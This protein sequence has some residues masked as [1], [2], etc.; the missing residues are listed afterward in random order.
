MWHISRGNVLRGVAKV[1][2][3]LLK[4]SFKSLVVSA[5]LSTSA[6]ETAFSQPRHHTLLRNLETRIMSSEEWGYQS[7]S[8]SGYTP[9]ISQR[10]LIQQASKPIS[11]QDG[12]QIPLEAQ[13]LSQSQPQS[14]ASTAD[15]GLFANISTPPPPEVDSPPYSPP[16][17]IGSPVPRSPSPAIINGND[18]KP[19]KVQKPKKLKNGRDK[20][21]EPSAA[22][23]G[24]PDPSPEYL[25]LAAYPP[26]QLPYA[27]KILVVIDLNGTLLY[28]PSRH[29][30]TSFVERPHARTFLRYCIDTFKVVIWSSAKSNNV[31]RMCAQLLTPEQLSRVVAVWGRERFGLS[32]DDYNTRVICYKRL[33]ALWADPT[34]AASHPEFAEGKRWSQ[35]DTLLVDDSIEKARSEPYNIIEIPEFEGHAT[36][37]GFVLPQVHDYINECAR[38]ADVSTYIR[39]QPFKTVPGWQLLPSNTLE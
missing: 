19:N 25:A 36:E 23:G 34:V 12:E 21:T 15:A 27:R 11:V 13:S 2:T 18:A 16:S 31:K 5:R 26:F 6:T 1:S 30:P 22:S 39:N 32:P 24:V 35:A 9:L 14:Q 29:N 10:S 37:P 8:G 4:P 28:R 33:S 38:Q 20:K 7:G 17:V 3:G